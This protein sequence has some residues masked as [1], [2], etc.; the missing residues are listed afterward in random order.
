MEWLNIDEGYL[1]YLRT[2]EKRI[3]NTNYGS[4]KMKPFFGKLFEI[5]DMIY[6]TQVSSYKDRHSKMKDNID[7]VKIVNEKGPLAVVNLNYMFPVNKKFVQTIEYANIGSL[8]AFKDADTMDKYI[9]LLKQEMSVI[10]TKDI[11]TKAQRLYALKKT[12]PNHFVSKR[13]F[14]FHELE[15]VCKEYVR[16]VELKQKINRGSDI[17]IE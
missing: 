3:P 13:C 2:A 5:E 4:D 8:V 10:K 6:V 9:S 15:R 17:E 1:N 7:F 16:H 14:A 12:D 11:G